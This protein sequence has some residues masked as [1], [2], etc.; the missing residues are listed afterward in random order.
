MTEEKNDKAEAEEKKPP[1]KKPPGYRKFEK[2]LK[3]VVNAPPLRKNPPEN[4]SQLE[5]PTAG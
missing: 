5:H 1:A 3:R 2:L 4:T